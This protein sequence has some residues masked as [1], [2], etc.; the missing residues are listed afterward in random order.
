MLLLI[1]YVIM[2]LLICYVI[3]L[4]IFISLVNIN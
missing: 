3:M 2:L 4:W 1:C